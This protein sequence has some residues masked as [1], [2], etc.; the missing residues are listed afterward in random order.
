[1]ARYTD[2]RNER[3]A[4]LVSREVRVKEL[5]HGRG[6]RECGV[7]VLGN[8]ATFKVLYLDLYCKNYGLWTLTRMKS[9]HVAVAVHAQWSRSGHSQ[10]C[11]LCKVGGCRY[12]QARTREKR[13]GRG[14]L[15]TSITAGETD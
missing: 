3:R 2:M 4:Y 10:A 5:G 6:E 14:G 12:Q 11:L 15:G 9:T 13:G 7:V 8:D 1:M